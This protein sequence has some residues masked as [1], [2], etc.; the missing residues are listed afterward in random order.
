MDCVPA[1]IKIILFS[2]EN[3]S[4][5]VTIIYQTTWS[6]KQMY[7]NLAEF[8]PYPVH[9]NNVL[10]ATA[11]IWQYLILFCYTDKFD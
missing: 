6:P 11:S 1:V 4:L 3:Y 5:A 2:I 9:S 7:T 10:D 8:T